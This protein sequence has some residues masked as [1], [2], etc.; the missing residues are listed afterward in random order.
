MKLNATQPLC[1][2]F[3]AAVSRVW[4][5]AGDVRPGPQLRGAGQALPV[6]ARPKAHPGL[7]LVAV[8]SPPVPS[9]RLGATPP[10]AACCAHCLWAPGPCTPSPVVSRICSLMSE[11]RSWHFA[12]RPPCSSRPDSSKA[13]ASG[14]ARCSDPNARPRLGLDVPTS[15]L[16][17]AQAG[18][19]RAGPGVGRRPPSHSRPALG[20]RPTPGD[21]EGPAA[22]RAG[23]GP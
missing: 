23:L 3:I 20:S 18:H 11:V 17:C 15:P 2:P 14:R 10:S 8:G 9:L 19:P 22:P 6:L 21:G 4:A 5:V 7:C 16:C 1:R 13:L 12:F